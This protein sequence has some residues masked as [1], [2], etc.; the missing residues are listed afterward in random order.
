ME[1]REFIL[2]TG[3]MITTTAFLSSF[4]NVNSLLANSPKNDN[5]AEPDKR[6]DP[7]IFAQ[8]ILK[9]IAL[10][11]NAPSPHNTQSW[12]FK[13]LSDIQMELFVDENI[14]LPA[15]EPLHDKSIWE[16]D[17]SLK[18]WY[19]AQV[20]SVMRQELH[21]FRRVIHLIRTLVKSLLPQ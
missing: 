17:A 2:K 4:G 13:I 1:R 16:Q 9:A 7:D 8:P 21:I 18:L 6:P 12:K 5:A 11:I 3:A 10:G 15:T 19:K 20:D 14:L